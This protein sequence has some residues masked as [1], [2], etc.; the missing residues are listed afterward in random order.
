MWKQAEHRQAEAEI[1]CFRQGVETC[2]GVGKTQQTGSPREKKERPKE[3]A[4]TLNTFSAMLI[5]QLRIRYLLFSV[6]PRIG[7]RPL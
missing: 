4:A 6:K 2:E 1:I 3:I 7:R 5:P